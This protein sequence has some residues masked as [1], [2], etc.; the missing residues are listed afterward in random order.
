MRTSFLLMGFLT[1]LAGCKDLEYPQNFPIVFTKNI[2][3]ITPDGAEFVGS[4]ES[5]GSDQDILNYGFVWSDQEMPNLSSNHVF[6]SDVVKEGKF[7][8]TITRDLEDATVYYVRAFVRTNHLIIY[9]NQVE[10]TSQGSTPP[11]ISDFTPKKGFD[12]TEI[13]IEGKNFSSRLE[14]NKVQIGPLY[15]R[16]LAANDSLLKV[17]TPSSRLRGDYKITVMVAGKSV[18]SQIPFTMLGPA[19]TE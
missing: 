1:F 3:R 10:F 14:G 19:T 12:G 18:V 7:S 17:V 15:V 9:G 2:E 5:F 4:L 16:V 8:K 6:I 13:T 11:A